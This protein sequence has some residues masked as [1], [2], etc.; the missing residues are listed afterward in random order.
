MQHAVRSGPCLYQGS[1]YEIFCPFCYANKKGRSNYPGHRFYRAGPRLKPLYLELNMKRE[2]AVAKIPKGEWHCPD[3][4]I[5]KNY[6]SL[7][8]GLSDTFW[9]DGKPRIPWTLTIRFDPET[10]NLCV[11]DK[12]G[13]KGAYTTGE[14]LSEALQLVEQAIVQGTLSWRKWKR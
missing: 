1:A 11:N 13:S 2:A 3:P 9:E 4:L 14:T 5:L 12:E 7:A 8:Q 10:V 6:P